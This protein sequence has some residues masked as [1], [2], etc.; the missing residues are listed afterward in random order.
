MTNVIFYIQVSTI[1]LQGLSRRLA[2]VDT[3]SQASQTDSNGGL[4]P[5]AATYPHIGGGKFEHRLPPNQARVKG[6]EFSPWSLRPNTEQVSP[7]PKVIYRPDYC[8]TVDGKSRPLDHHV[9]RNGKQ[10]SVQNSHR[11]EKEKILLPKST[12]IN[13]LSDN[14]ISS[15]NSDEI[16]RE[17]ILKLDHHETNAGKILSPDTQKAEDGKISSLDACEKMDGEV[18]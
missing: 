9:A 18:T 4:S 5:M 12:Y 13:S 1:S 10:F 6:K 3:P 11:T 14:E 17:E 2:Y 7:V 16:I 15:S 8:Q